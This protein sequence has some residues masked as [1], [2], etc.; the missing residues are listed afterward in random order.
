MV[1]HMQALHPEPGQPKS[2]C[3][4]LIAQPLRPAGPGWKGGSSQRLGEADGSPPTPQTPLA[5]KMPLAEAKHSVALGPTRTD[6]SQAQTSGRPLLLPHNSLG[7]PWKPESGW[8][9]ELL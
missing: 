4:L 5:S 6:R 2:Q 3:P 9:E 7:G 8:Q 1:P